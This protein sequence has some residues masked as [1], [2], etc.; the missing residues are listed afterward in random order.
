MT[1]AVCTFFD[2]FW[3]ETPISIPH[4]QKKLHLLNPY[5]L[6]TL[7]LSLTDKWA[8]ALPVGA[9]PRRAP[10]HPSHSL[11][12]AGPLLND[13]QKAAVQA[14]LPYAEVTLQ[15]HLAFHGGVWGMAP[16]PLNE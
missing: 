8:S 16:E 15:N 6:R 2:V 5:A 4:N 10:H 3:D 12:I 9:V 13:D 1:N 7:L 14:M 11:E